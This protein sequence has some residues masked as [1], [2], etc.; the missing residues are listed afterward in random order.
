MRMNRQHTIADLRNPCQLC[1]ESESVSPAR[2]LHCAG[3]CN[4]EAVVCIFKFWRNAGSSSGACHLNL[5]APGAAARCF[6]IAGLR[7]ARI[8]L[9]RIRV[10]SGL[11]PVGAPLMHVVT[12]IVESIRIRWVKAHLLRPIF[13]SRGI[14]GNL[15]RR[16]ISPGIQCVVHAAASCA[17]P[18]GFRR[19]AVLSGGDGFQPFAIGDCVMPGD[20]DN[21]LSRIAEIRVADVRLTE[22]GR[23][24]VSRGGEEEC[25]VRV[26]G[27]IGRQIKASTHTRCT[28]FSSSR[29]SAQPMENQPSGIAQRIGVE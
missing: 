13:P 19:Q 18:F 3:T 2:S 26:G 5:M 14:I 23:A 8:S 15:I 17:F 4:A 7:A 29:P 6:A 28:G 1:R 27:L 20:C 21:R 9:R 10:I 25:V 22:V 12:E 11:V 24:R 16:R